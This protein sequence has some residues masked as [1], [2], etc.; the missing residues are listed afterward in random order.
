MGLQTHSLETHKILLLTGALTGRNRS[1]PSTTTK[2]V[3]P[4]PSLESGPI[5]PLSRS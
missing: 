1:I 3:I 4:H 5:L 2:L